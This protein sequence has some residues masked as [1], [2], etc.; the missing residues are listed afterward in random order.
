VI[1]G[2]AVFLAAQLFK[3]R[4]G[5]GA[6]SGSTPALDTSPLDAI[7]ASPA[8]SSALAQT[9][10]ASVP[11]APVAPVAPVS[12][13]EL[14]AL[15][16]PA[17]TAATP[18]VPA[19]PSVPAS[20]RPVS[21]SELAALTAPAATPALPAGDDG[22]SAPLTAAEER[23]AM[24]GAQSAARALH[25]YIMSTSSARR[26]RVRVRALQAAMGGVTVDGLIGRE[27]AARI[28]ELTGLRIPGLS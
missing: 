10:S 11:V 15:T 21:S 3:P 24:A 1:K 22:A 27:T 4:E 12:S 18:E 6:S 5:E 7:A 20:W 23:E 16:A 17:A 28:R 13:S 25:A 9:S 8:P 14:A 26:D 19:T 2:L